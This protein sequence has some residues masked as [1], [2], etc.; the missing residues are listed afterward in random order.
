MSVNVY[1]VDVFSSLTLGGVSSALHHG[2]TVTVDGVQYVQMGSG[3]LKA[4]DESWHDT[5]EAAYRAAASKLA[6]IST[7]I[8]DQLTRWQEGRA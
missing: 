1:Q 3:W 5:P 6:T 7:R 2:K 4:R 8:N